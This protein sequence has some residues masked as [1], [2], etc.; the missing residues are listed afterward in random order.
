MR[1]AA[2]LI[3][4]RIGRGDAG[5]VFDLPG[6]NRPA[7]DV[8]KKT[9]VDWVSKKISARG[10]AAGVVNKPEK[11][12]TAIAHDLRRSFGYRWARGG[13][14]VHPHEDD[15]AH[16]D[17]HLA[18]LRRRPR[19]RYGSPSVGHR[20]RRELGRYFMGHPGRSGGADEREPLE[21]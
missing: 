1:Q 7:T 6:R 4:E 20:G 14:R 2:E 11:G 9:A 8:G 15:A 5:F 17:S 21:N 13:A 12:C 19:R 10:K 3:E 16:L 18:D